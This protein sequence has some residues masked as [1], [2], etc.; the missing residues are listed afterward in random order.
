L[1]L[2]GSDD[3]I[4]DWI[5]RTWMQCISDDVKKDSRDNISDDQQDRRDGFGLAV[6]GVWDGKQT[7]MKVRQESCEGNQ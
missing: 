4:N 2:E 3:S 7:T 5:Q 1:K 6:L